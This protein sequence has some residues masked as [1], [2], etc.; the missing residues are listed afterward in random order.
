VE[1][2]G[3]IPAFKGRF[4]GV[5]V[6]VATQLLIGVIHVAFGFALLFGSFSA[7]FSLSPIVYSAYTLAY[8]LLTLLFAWLVWVGK[9]SGW[10]GTVAVSLFVIFAD[11][12]TVLVLLSFLG[13]P[14]FAAF[15][16]IPFSILVIAY[17]VQPHVRSK[18]LI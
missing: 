12:L 2:R 16:E 1:Q 13:I 5:A 9:R 3:Q 18:Y 15:G 17:L 10:L 8:A 7:A 6:L 4:L 14:K 11:A